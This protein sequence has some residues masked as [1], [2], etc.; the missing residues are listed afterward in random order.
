MATGDRSEAARFIMI[1]PKEF[2]SGRPSGGPEFSPRPLAGCRVAARR[3]VVVVLPPFLAL[4]FSL[5]GPRGEKRAS[6]VAS[7]LVTLRN[8]FEFLFPPDPASL[9]YCAPALA[10]RFNRN[11]ILSDRERNLP[12]SHELWWIEVS[13]RRLALP[14]WRRISFGYFQRATYAG[15]M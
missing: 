11:W 2:T 5:H 15:I 10:S 9:K 3:A 12:D 8:F 6:L 4:V 7:S 14:R 1:T 13:S